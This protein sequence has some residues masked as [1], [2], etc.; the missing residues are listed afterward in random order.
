[1]NVNTLRIFIAPELRT[2]AGP[3]VAWTWRQSLAALGY[4]W[5]EVSSGDECDIAHVVDREQAVQARLGIA[6]SLAHWR[7]PARWRLAGAT[8]ESAPLLLRFESE[9][10]PASGVVQ[11]GATTWLP[12][13]VIFDLFWLLTGQ[14]ERHWPQD[15][16]GFYTL[17]AQWDEPRV[18]EQALGSAIV[19]ALGAL[20][21]ASGCGNPLARWPQGKRAAAA[22]S[23][24]VDY[25]EVIRWL[26][27][28]RITRR[29]GRAGFGPAW[30]VLAGRRDHWVFPQW[31]DFEAQYGVRSAFYFVARK[32]SLVEYARGTPDPFYD[33][34]TPRFRELFQRL[35]GSGW[36]VGMHASYRAYT[37]RE[38]FAGEKQRLEQAAGAPVLGN[39]HHYWHMNP[40]DPE[41]TL[42]VHAD[43]G[44]V[45]DT[46]LMHDRYLGWRRS[47]CIPYFPFATRRGREIGAVQLPVTW[48]DAQL[49]QRGD[50]S[51]TEREHR[52]RGLVD[53]VAEQRGIFVA[54]VHEYVLDDVLFPGWLATLRA[55]LERITVR[56]DFWVATPAAIAQHW[57]DRY[58]SLLA[59]SSGLEEGR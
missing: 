46:S 10:A 27:P 11:E 1:M 53:R 19:E 2:L 18:L 26:E 16:H 55:A 38:A 41:E 51:Q 28:L 12:R 3:A 9:S 48:M 44:L 4:S 13:D 33:V 23:H 29:Q 47:T 58:R 15:R 5:Q 21:R 24:D 37:S 25:P 49:S 30:E 54:D 57:R 35:A 34:E 32:G 40:A 7:D 8:P 6:A 56:G 45:Y 22:I 52:L 39:R 20:L 50:L 14:E 17:P 43:I 42:Q 36:E 59:A 31:M